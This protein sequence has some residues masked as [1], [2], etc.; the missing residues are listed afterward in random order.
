M[1]ITDKVF[2]SENSVIFNEAENHMHATKV[3]MVA[4]LEN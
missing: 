1:E 2:R 3:V 4:T